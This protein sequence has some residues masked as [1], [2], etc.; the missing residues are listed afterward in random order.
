MPEVSRRLFKKLEYKELPVNNK[1]QNLLVNRLES[2][3]KLIDLASNTYAKLLHQHRV[4]KI[5]KCVSEYYTEKDFEKLTKHFF[6]LLENGRLWSNKDRGKLFYVWCVER[7]VEKGWHVHLHTF[8]NEKKNR[9]TGVSG[10]ISSAWNKALKQYIPSI[11]LKEVTS[12]SY[13]SSYVH[14]C[15][16]PNDDYKYHRVL[17][18]GNYTQLKASFYWIS[19]ICKVREGTKPYKFGRTQIK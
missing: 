5:P 8:V 1:E 9:S 12:E 6:K 16:I 11:E 19:Y 14:T 2:C 17:N 13:N 18:R 4:L 10:I 15:T 3:Y 7:E